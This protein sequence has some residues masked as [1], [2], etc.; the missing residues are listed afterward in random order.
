[1]RGKR[2]RL[3]R[4]HVGASTSAPGYFERRP[5]VYQ[6]TAPGKILKF[7]TGLKNAIKKP[8]AFQVTGQIISPRG[9]AYR[10]AK[11]AWVRRPR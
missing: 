7:F 3:I 11:R 2:A 9:S 6:E 1:M 4:R 8:K 5:V 10:Q